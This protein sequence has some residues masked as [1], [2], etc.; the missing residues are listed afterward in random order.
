MKVRGLNVKTR[1]NG[2]TGFGNFST[3]FFGCLNNV[4]K[5]IIF[6]VSLSLTG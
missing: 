1:V 4:P 2:I 5:I 3:V 6:Y